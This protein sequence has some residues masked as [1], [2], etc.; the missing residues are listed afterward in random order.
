MDNSQHVVC[1]KSSV[2]DSSESTLIDYNLSTKDIIL[3]QKDIAEQD[4][5]YLKVIPT[6]VIMHEGKLWAFKRSAS[7]QV[8]VA[9]ESDLRL[10]DLII[11]GAHI[12]L[13]ESFDN[14]FYQQLENNL[15]LG[16][17]V[18]KLD[19]LPNL[20][21]QDIQNDTTGVIRHAHVYHL[22]GP[23]VQPAENDLNVLGFLTPEELLSDSFNC[24][25]AT[26]N[27]CKAILE[28]L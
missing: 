14:Y 19:V 5:D 25:T 26:K 17:Y 1:I 15:S 12:D 13:D 24:D 16:S 27:I 22:D 10:N 18:V 3:C 28:G 6:T 11:K 9:F 8:S 20:L 2:V 21:C 23:N 4:S 7:A